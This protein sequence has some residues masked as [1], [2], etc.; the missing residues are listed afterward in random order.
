MA[1]RRLLSD[2]QPAPFWA[3]A[4]DERAIVRNYTLSRAD[5]DLIAKKADG[6]QSSRVCRAHVWHG[7]SWPRARRHR[8]TAR[9]GDGFYRRSGRACRPRRLRP[10]G[11]VRQVAG[12][13]SPSLTEEDGA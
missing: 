6:T 5:F 13:M 7:L 11:I 3:W 1:R 9:S 10:I 2:E 8:D 12:N 4:S